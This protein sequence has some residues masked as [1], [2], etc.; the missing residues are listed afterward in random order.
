MDEERAQPHHGAE[1]TGLLDLY[2]RCVSEAYRVTAE[3]FEGLTDGG[4]LFTRYDGDCLIG[5]ALMRG[6]S[7]TLLCV[8]EAYR[9]QGIGSDLLKQAEDWAKSHGKKRLILGHGSDYV[10]QGVPAETGA[11]SFFAKRGYTCTGY[12]YDMT[13]TLPAEKTAE[14]PGGV[15]FE[16]TEAD[17]RVLDAVKDVEKSWLGVYESTDEDVLLAKVNGKIAGFC[18]VSAWNRFSDGRRDVGSVSCVGVL[19]EYRRRGIGLAMV[20]EALRYLADEG[21]AC[22]ELL[23]TS[24]PHWYGKLGFVPFHRLWMGEKNL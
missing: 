18:M 2:N 7:L 9:R 21:L 20:S 4:E 15:T 6:S 10:L 8:D 22:A 11:D 17:A 3:A 13:V 5:Y 24:I 16:L 19:P 12:T 14:I 23:Y 1:V